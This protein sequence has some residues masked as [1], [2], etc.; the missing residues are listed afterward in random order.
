MIAASKGRRVLQQ[1]FSAAELT[2]ETLSEPFIVRKNGEIIKIAAIA[3][4]DNAWMALD[5][6]LVRP[7]GDMRA[8]RERYDEREDRARHDRRAREQG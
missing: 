7:D 4:I 6:G 5:I 2:S 3:N 1:Q 8:R